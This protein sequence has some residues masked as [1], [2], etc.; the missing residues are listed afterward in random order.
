MHP[1]EDEGE[2]TLKREPANNQNSLLWG[3]RV[4]GWEGVTCLIL[5]MTYL[6]WQTSL[7]EAFHSGTPKYHLQ[8]GNISSLKI[9]TLPDGSPVRPEEGASGEER[10][11]EASQGTEGETPQ[12]GGKVQQAEENGDFPTI[13]FSALEWSP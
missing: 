13:D 12:R 5:L 2:T 1:E 10:G 9:D 11:G 3:Q 8:N 6:L 4:Q 7:T